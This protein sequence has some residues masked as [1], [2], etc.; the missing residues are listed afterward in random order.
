[1]YLIRLV[2]IRSGAVRPYTQ[3]RKVCVIEIIVNTTYLYISNRLTVRRL[4][5]VV[6]LSSAAT[7]TFALVAC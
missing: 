7:A 4:K 2:F 1:M 6:A 5:V 3:G